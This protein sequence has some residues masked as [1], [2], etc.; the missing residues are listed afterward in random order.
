M[1]AGMVLLGSLV[2]LDVL[3]TGWALWAL[4]NVRGDQQMEL[5]LLK[6]LWEKELTKQKEK[7]FSD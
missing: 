6:W 4:G 7:G 1:T 2:G 5:G 3:M